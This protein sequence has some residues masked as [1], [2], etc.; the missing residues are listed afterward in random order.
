MYSIQDS[1]IKL[2]LTWKL[3]CA[4]TLYMVVEVI[5]AK[6]RC[7]S[8]PD[9]EAVRATIQPR[10]IFTGSPVYCWASA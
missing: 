9:R 8:L 3:N 5:P 6:S 7:P 10:S 1:T 4:L 2:C